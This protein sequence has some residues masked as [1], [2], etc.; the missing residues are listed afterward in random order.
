MKIKFILLL[1]FGIFFTT[2][3]Q[4][5]I[6]PNG[7]ADAKP[8][9]PKVNKNN[10]IFNSQSSIDLART[11]RAGKNSAVEVFR[12]LKPNTPDA[13]NVSA[14]CS[15]G[16]SIH[17]IIEALQSDGK[18]ALETVDLLKN[19]NGCSFTRIEILREVKAY[20]RIPLNDLVPIIQNKF[21]IITTEIVDCLVKISPSDEEI[22][23]SIAYNRMA[24]NR[25]ELTAL[26]NNKLRNFNND[27][28]NNV[29]QL[30]RRIN[31]GTVEIN[32][33]TADSL[34]YLQATPLKVLDVFFT[35]YYLR[36][37]PDSAVEIAKIGKYLH[38][39]RDD[40]S[41]FLRGKLY[42]ATQVLDALQA[43]YGS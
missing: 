8:N 21:T 27:H 1:S 33:D 9:L 28:Y 25:K 20:Y 40:V 19:S 16:F 12:A 37:T 23:N 35:S 32:Q 14:L 5:I 39:S 29:F 18:T 15:A 31:I 26:L 36:P 7:D 22:A 2:K 41:T 3:A 42:T 4:H 24:S 17:N 13:E 10:S 6:K 11:L 34:L 43:V 30:L 38:I